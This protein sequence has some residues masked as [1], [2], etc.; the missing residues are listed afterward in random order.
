MVT[1]IA[2]QMKRRDA[3]GGD[4]AAYQHGIKLM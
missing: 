4:D 1:D 3:A 2:K